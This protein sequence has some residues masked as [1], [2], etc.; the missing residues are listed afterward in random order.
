MSP[1]STL[2][3]RHKAGC[4]PTHRVY[5]TSDSDSASLSISATTAA[6]AI[7]TRAMS[8]DMKWAEQVTAIFALGVAGIQRLRPLA[9]S[10]R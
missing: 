7:A 9:V 4:R 10:P 2:T 6:T 5:L 8:R 1:T 3:R